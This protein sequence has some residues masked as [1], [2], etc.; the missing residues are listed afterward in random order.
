L[1]VYYVKNC[2]FATDLTILFQTVKKVVS[3]SDINTS[4]SA[5]TERF[6]GSSNT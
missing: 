5:T 4:G 1:D 6:K 2:N 3:R